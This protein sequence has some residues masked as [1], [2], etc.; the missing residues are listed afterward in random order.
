MRKPSS[1]HRFDDHRHDRQLSSVNNSR[2]SFLRLVKSLLLILPV[3]FL[4]LQICSLLGLIPQEII[5]SF[6]KMS[7]DTTVESKSEQDQDEELD[8][9]GNAL[10][11]DG[12]S[13]TAVREFPPMND[14]EWLDDIDY[15]TAHPNYKSDI[16]G[17]QKCLFESIINNNNSLSH[18]RYGYLIAIERERKIGSMADYLSLNKQGWDKGH[19]LAS[20]FDIKHLMLTEP[21]LID[22]DL[23]L[24]ISKEP[25]FGTLSKERR[26]TSTPNNHEDLTKHNHQLIV[27]PIQLAP[28]GS[29]LFGCS[30]AKLRN[31]KTSL[32]NIDWDNTVFSA[33]KGKEQNEE[34]F[35]QQFETQLRQDLNAT[36]RTLWSSEG[37]CLWADFQLLID[38]YKG[39]IYHLDF[40]RCFLHKGYF[41]DPSRQTLCQ[42]ALLEHADELMNTVRSHFGPF[43]TTLSFSEIFSD[44]LQDLHQARLRRQDLP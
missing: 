20:K 3:V 27:Q 11:L 41:S 15:T 40:D 2:V 1:M 26:H 39:S 8:N 32:G 44:M 36:L 16:C 29:Y 22:T 21:H 30:K 37:F 25:Y 6:S 24:E 7:D 18:D 33:A 13:A 35:L 38:P 4:L 9:D 5:V 43:N 19:E 10:L 23:R 28:E 31:A 12:T 42:R 34:Q 14:T 17:T